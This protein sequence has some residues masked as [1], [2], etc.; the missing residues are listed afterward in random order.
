[1]LLPCGKTVCKIHTEEIADIICIFCNKLHQI[2][3]DGLPVNEFVEMQLEMQL[4]RINLNF[5]HLTDCQVLLDDLNKKL[6]EVELIRKDKKDF[7]YEYFNEIAREVGLRRDTLIRDIEEYSN[8]IIENI[9]KLRQ[10]CLESSSHHLKAAENLFD[11]C[12]LKVKIQKD[13]FE[14]FEIYDKKFEEVLSESKALQEELYP[15]V[16]KYKFGLLGNKSYRFESK[17]IKISEVFGSLATLNYQLKN[18]Y[19]DKVNKI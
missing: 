13:K 15:V 16:E 1:V 17:E 14:S 19:S 18:T 5:C 6:S 8:E 2:T 9:S 4:N 3:E 7:I 12:K 11:A 10:E